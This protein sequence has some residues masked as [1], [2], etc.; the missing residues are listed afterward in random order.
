[1]NFYHLVKIERPDLLVRV[2][3]VVIK[4]RDWDIRGRIYISYQG[5]NAQFSG[6]TEQALAYTEWVAAQ[7]AFLGLQW[8]S[9]AVPQSV[10]PR[11]KCKYV[12]LS[13]P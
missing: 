13:S 11:L 1:M 10:F 12:P 5:I 8:R 7:P 2:H 4:A 3:K 9:Y 6:P